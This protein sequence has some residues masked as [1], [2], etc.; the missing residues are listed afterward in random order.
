[1]GL[2]C[3]PDFAQ[4]IMEHVLCGLNNVEAY[5]DNID[6]FGNTWGKY[7]ALLDKILSCL[8]ANGFPVNTLK[9]A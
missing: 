8:E 7:Q 6:I 9:C 4:Q 2:K 3:A 5:L 1:M